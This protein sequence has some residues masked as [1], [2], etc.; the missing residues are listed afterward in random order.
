[1]IGPKKGKECGSDQSSRLWE[2]VL[3]DDPKNNCIGD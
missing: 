2:G 3:H 1:M